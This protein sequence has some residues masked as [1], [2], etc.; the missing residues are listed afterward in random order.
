MIQTQRSK[1]RIDL[2]STTPPAVTHEVHASLNAVA[3]RDSAAGLV[4]ALSAWGQHTARKSIEQAKKDAEGYEQL[5]WRDAA[6]GEENEALADN[7]AYVRGRQKQ[8]ALADGLELA[9]ASTKE[10]N[11]LQREDPN[12][13][14]E[15]WKQDKLQTYLADREGDPEAMQLANGMAT[16]FMESVE[17]G[18]HATKAKLELADAENDVSRTFAAG[19]TGGNITTPDELKLAIQQSADNTALDYEEARGIAFR[20]LTTQMEVRGERTADQY[21]SF[22]A[23]AETMAGEFAGNE[24][25]TA[26]FTAALERGRREVATM[27]EHEKRD[28]IEGDLKTWETMT[29]RVNNGS[30]S[31]AD[32]KQLVDSGYMTA[33]QAAS[34]SISA[35]DNRERAYV[36]AQKAAAE[37][38]EELD[39]RSHMERGEGR[40][41]DPKRAQK[42]AD[43][44]FSTAFLAFTAARRSGD[45]AAQDQ[46][47]VSVASAIAIGRKNQTIPVGL[48]ERF[49]SIHMSNPQMVAEIG[50]D[51]TALDRA[52]LGKFIQAHTSDEAYATLNLYSDMRKSMRMDSQ[53][54][55]QA[56]TTMA[57]R[58]P[59]EVAGEL[60]AR[61]NVIRNAAVRMAGDAVNPAMAENE[62][63]KFARF[64]LTMGRDADSA[65]RL[66]EK[67]VADR[68]MPVGGALIPAGSMTAEDPEEL[69]G[70]FLDGPLRALVDEKMP[71]AYDGLDLF[72]S[73]LPN[74]PGQFMVMD[75]N[76]QP[77]VVDG[78][79]Q[80]VDEADM[81]A[82]NIEA[83]ARRKRKEDAQLPAN[84]NTPLVFGK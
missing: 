28:R 3:E 80:F 23:K 84:H 33:Q 21:E 42:A 79:I 11:Q 58:D 16:R 67:A 43:G 52:G 8:R 59:G 9:S 53:Q 34:W 17:S 63:K 60:R 27:R 49:N 48:K 71:G 37:A 41:F 83:A 75:S 14:F 55:A 1:N 10:L 69:V 74:Q 54:A 30:F 25:H 66:A 2:S 13:D 4:N 56:L 39:F 18:Y 12:F 40:I 45:Q 64:Y 35:A 62:I 65:L 29:Q 31:S 32:A 77:V 72:V 22:L 46:A 51:F 73:P 47:A 68:L 76:Y 70:N 38:Q 26:Q 78:K 7:A 82:R 20:H 24:G 44:M 6:T 5:G 81:A 36:K 57:H 15:T 19:F 50:E 61:S